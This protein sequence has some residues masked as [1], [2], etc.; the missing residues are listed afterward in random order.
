MTI[1]V[2]KNTDSTRRLAFHRITS[3]DGDRWW[4]LNLG[5]CTLLVNHPA[6][7]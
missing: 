5:V 1:E 7:R 4:L 3:V 2:L 6:Q